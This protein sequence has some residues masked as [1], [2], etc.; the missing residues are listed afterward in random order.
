[1]YGFCECSCV[2]ER[3]I[4]RN[5]D[6]DIAT[7]W[8]ATNLAAWKPVNR[9][10]KHFKS[11]HWPTPTA[12]LSTYRVL[13]GYS[14]LKFVLSVLGLLMFLIFIN[15]L[16]FHLV[17]DDCF[18]V[19]FMYLR[20]CSVPLC[21]VSLSCPVYVIA[22]GYHNVFVLSGQIKIDRCIE[23]FTSLV[24]V[25]FCAGHCV[26]SRVSFRLTVNKADSLIEVL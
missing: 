3:R 9:S 11:Y 23:V 22:L 14:F 24:L 12:L 21:M 20:Q 1:M 13:V 7:I 15:E 2:E 6:I 26:Y 10:A 4:W 5:Q 8:R 16:A 17:W 18:L 19:I 25:T